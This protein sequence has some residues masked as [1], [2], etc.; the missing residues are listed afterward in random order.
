MNIAISY[1][2]EIKNSKNIYLV[3]KS[4]EILL[5]LSIYHILIFMTIDIFFN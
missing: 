3:I 5:V 2:V 4:V 1:F